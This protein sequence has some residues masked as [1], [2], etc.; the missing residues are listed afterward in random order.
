MATA[1]TIISRAMRLIGVLSDGDTPSASESSDGLEA[2]NSMLGLWANERLMINATSLD[3]VVLTPGKAAYTIGP[4]GEIDTVRPTDVDPMSYVLWGNVSYP[5]VVL[6]AQEYNAICLK[7]LDGTIPQ[8]IW[9]LPTFPL[10]QIT[11]YGVPSEAMTLK[12]WSWKPLSSFGALTT[13]VILP[14]GYEEALAFNLAVSIAPEYQVE[15][16]PTV[17]QRAMMSKKLL[18]RTNLEVPVLEPVNSTLPRRQF[19]IFSGE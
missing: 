12:L 3:S 10:G 11:L 8:A 7:D 6:T 4:G 17:K 9:Y 15:A 18:K 1:I 5:L 16:A 19:N 14:P 2:L 13:D